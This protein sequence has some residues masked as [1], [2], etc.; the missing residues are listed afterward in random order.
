M[1][2]EKFQIMASLIG[3][4][5]NWEIDKLREAMEEQKSILGNEEHEKKP[6]VRHTFEVNQVSQ[7][8]SSHI[9]VHTA[10]YN[11]IE[12]VIPMYM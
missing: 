5:K 9:A 1:L 2:F 10:L 7:S 4:K 11:E 8:I 12:F 3:R 6:P